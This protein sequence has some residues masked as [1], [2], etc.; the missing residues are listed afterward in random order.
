M[1]FIIRLIT[2][3]V[4]LPTSHLSLIL[5]QSLNYLSQFV[6]SFTVVTRPYLRSVCS[7]DSRLESN[8]VSLCLGLH[9][10]LLWILCLPFLL[11][12]SSI[13]RST[14]LSSCHPNICECPRDHS[15]LHTCSSDPPTEPPLRLLG[16]AQPCI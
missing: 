8:P 12:V 4:E 6:Q 7:C 10:T 3:W 9:N 15:P 14:C 11:R 16:L 13:S 5:G 2:T 1:C